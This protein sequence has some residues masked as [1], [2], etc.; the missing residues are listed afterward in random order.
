M[1]QY[2]LVHRDG[3]ETPCRSLKEVT[4]RFTRGDAVTFDWAGR[5]RRVHVGHPQPKPKDNTR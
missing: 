4:Q 3:T 1:S 2:T 5:I